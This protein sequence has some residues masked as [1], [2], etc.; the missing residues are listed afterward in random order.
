MPVR[1]AQVGDTVSYRNQDGETSNVLVTG[2][3]PAAA[4]A[5][6]VVTAGTEG[7]LAS[8]TY[9]YRITAVVGGAESEA[10]AAGSAAVTG[11]NGSAEVTLPG[12]P[13][14]QYA[15]YG[16]TGG[17]EEFMFLSEL[18]ATSFVDGGSLTP[19]SGQTATGITADGRIGAL[20]FHPKRVLGPSS[21][22]ALTKATT[23]EDTEVY[24]K[25]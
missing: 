9:S 14:T 10:S 12:D 5:A 23:L 19:V 17:T 6:P 18:G 21:G 2:V 4:P 20:Q 8:A 1:D 25:Y 15:I 11:P 7:S 16:R 3:Q 22:V 13:N 24:F